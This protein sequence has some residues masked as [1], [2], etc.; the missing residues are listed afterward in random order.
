MTHVF[1]GRYVISLLNVQEFL[2]GLVSWVE[3]IINEAD[4][5]K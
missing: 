4:E 1:N 3:K 2:V 5:V